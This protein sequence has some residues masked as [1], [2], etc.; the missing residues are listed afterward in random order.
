MV[1]ALVES[2]SDVINIDNHIYVTSDIFLR[3]LY[4][5]DEALV[6]VPP[7]YTPH[8]SDILPDTVRPNR[9][10]LMISKE[11]IVLLMLM[12]PRSVLEP[13]KTW[14]LHHISRFHDDTWREWGYIPRRPTEPETRCDK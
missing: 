5:D 11:G 8:L 4:L 12:S 1:E 14:V 3:S 9:T 2:S 10:K 13:F 6:S 7:Q